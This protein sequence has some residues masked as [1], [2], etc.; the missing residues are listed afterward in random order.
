LDT[1]GHFLDENADHNVETRS[2][3]EEETDLV[4][5]KSEFR[6]S[7]GEDWLEVDGNKITHGSR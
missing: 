2:D 7:H 6:D 3:C 5:L 4:L 1:S